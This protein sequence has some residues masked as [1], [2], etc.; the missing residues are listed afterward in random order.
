ME[1]A[2]GYVL[3]RCRQSTARPGCLRRARAQ[4][5]RR[6]EAEAASPR[7]CQAETRR[8]TGAGAQ[9]RTALFSNRVAALQLESPW[10]CDSRAILFATAWADYQ[11]TIVSHQHGIDP[12]CRR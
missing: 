11:S 6:D 10:P 1:I 9:V 4:V 3:R 12:T 8:H 2:A 7:R 5:Q